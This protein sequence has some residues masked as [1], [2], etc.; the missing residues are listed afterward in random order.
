[1]PQP[2]LIDDFGPDAIEYPETDGEPMAESDDQRD[3]LMYAVEALRLYFAAREDVYV[4]GNLLLYYEQGNPK[5]CVASDCFVV[6]GVPGHNR[7]IYKTWEEGKGPDFVLEITSRST[8]A[9]D[10]GPKRGT[11]AFLGVSEYWQYD[12]TGDYLDPRLQGYTLINGEYRAIPR[13]HPF[14]ES[15]YLVSEV[16]GLELHVCAGQLRLRD[17]ATGHFLPSLAESEA[18]RREAEAKLAALQA[19]LQR[20]RGD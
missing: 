17:P 7:R 1:M 11:Y 16:L 6:F 2:L 12:P 14:G 5:S 8:R 20:M 3:Y 10:L 9:E 4:S 13:P 18:A 15:F 19:E